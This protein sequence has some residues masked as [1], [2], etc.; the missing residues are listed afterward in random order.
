MAMDWTPGMNSK[1]RIEFR[2]MAPL[3]EGAAHANCAAIVII[4][5]RNEEAGLGATLDGLGA[6]VDVAGSPLAKESFE[7]LL[8]L[9]NCTD[10]SMAVA[11][12]WKAAHP[13][14]ALHIVERR[15]TRKYAHVGM[16][17]R[18]L[19]DT[20]WRRLTRTARLTHTFSSDLAARSAKAIL[21]TDADTVVAPDWIARNLRALRE[22]ADAVGGAIRLKP[23]DLERLPSAARQAYLRDQRYQRLVAELED[24]IDPQA[25]DPWPRHLEHFGA[26]LACRPEMY[27]RAGGVPPISQLEDV[28]FVDQLRRMDAR[29]RHDPKVVV[30]TSSRMHGRVGAGLSKQLS[31]WQRM[32]ER[33]EEHTVLSAAWLTHRFGVLRRLRELCCSGSLRGAAALR[34]FPF[35]WRRRLIGAHAG[36]TTV[37]LFLSE[38]DCDRL[39]E[40]TFH[41]EREGAIERVNRSLASAI[42][43]I[44]QQQSEAALAVEFAPSDAAAATL[45][46]VQ[47]E[48]NVQAG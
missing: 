33:G 36:R 11:Q 9:N 4:P 22:G 34:D 20:A 12:A 3:I 8:L 28:A 48:E 43:R 27:A 41:G 31:L 7:I 13:G 21:S 10:N 40:E 6:Q 37:G 19:M 38:I 18:M 30:H 47:T 26:S 45:Q 14:I 39:I 29:L 25:G 16:A 1:T 23:G 32:S 17:R 42:M 24:L 44:R 5:A 15:L 2:P 35:A 46:P